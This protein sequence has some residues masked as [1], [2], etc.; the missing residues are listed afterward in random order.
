MAEI[1]PIQGDIDDS[2]RNLGAFDLCD[3]PCQTRCDVHPARADTDQDQVLDA[4]IPL[5]DL[6]GDA[7]QDSF[8]PLGV[9]HHLRLTHE[10]RPLTS[11]PYLEACSWTIDISTPSWSL[12]TSF[13]GVS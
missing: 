11:E 8:D 9:D 13:K 2:Q 5:H 4:A 12:R 3:I 6:V 10:Q 1:V 7:R